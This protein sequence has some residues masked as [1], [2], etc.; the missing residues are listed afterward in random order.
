M[1][2]ATLVIAVAP[3]LDDLPRVNT[4]LKEFCSEQDLDDKVLFQLDLILDE[5]LSN[6]IRYG[7]EAVEVT[8]AIWLRLERRS[9]R[10][11]VT[12]KDNGVAFDPRLKAAPETI[13]PDQPLG[14]YGIHLVKN[15]ADEINY[16]RRNGWN[17]L[18]VVVRVA[19]PAETNSS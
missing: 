1:N 17:C 11:V 6:T 3:H 15:M 18:Q 12:V 4:L 2:A 9:D 5:L 16:W 7:F 14:G 8:P 13:R 10:V 19:P